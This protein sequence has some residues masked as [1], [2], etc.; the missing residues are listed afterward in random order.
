MRLQFCSSLGSKR[1][2]FSRQ[3][4]S[5]GLCCDATEG[6]IFCGKRA[7][8]AHAHTR[9]THT[10]GAN[11]THGARRHTAHADTRRT[12]IQ[13]PDALSCTHLDFSK[14]GIWASKINRGI[15]FSLTKR[16]MLNSDADEG[17]KCSQIVTRPKKAKNLSKPR[18]QMYMK[19]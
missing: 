16:P 15:H 11:N 2:P 3:A 13:N 4:K 19:R 8:H 9:R 12:Q 18:G 1:K 6:K 14:C 17:T 5:V 7:A 10:H